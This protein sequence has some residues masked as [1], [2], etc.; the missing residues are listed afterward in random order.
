MLAGCRFLLLGLLLVGF[1]LPATAQPA[2]FTMQGAF[3]AA[4][5]KGDLLSTL[6]GLSWRPGLCLAGGRLD[7]GQTRSLALY[8]QADVRYGVVA[9]AGGSGFDLD[10]R[11]RDDEGTV[12][13]RDTSADDTPILEFT[14]PVAGRYVLQ[15]SL[16]G[17][18]EPNVPACLAVLREGGA[19]L[20]AATLEA[21]F[22]ELFAV[23]GSRDQP[24]TN[25]GWLDRPDQWSF[26][27]FVLERNDGISLDGLR[28]GQGGR[29]LFASSSPGIDNLDLY[30][31]SAN[32][33]II[34]RDRTDSYRVT[35]S[36]EVTDDE[37]LSLH[38][39][40]PRNRE[41]GV[42]SIGFFKD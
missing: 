25:G 41:P 28:L 6:T 29:T 7:V 12:V 22:V 21:A 37:P 9:S 14:V 8:L 42:V 31:G 38:L 27:G 1:A 2:G 11:L 26:Y 5:V 15:L 35:L 13:S 18:P 23:A 19:D 36:L 39:H 16:V 34:A 33:A 3:R 24:L 30:L 20:Q 17:G 4:R 32:G 40:A 10:L